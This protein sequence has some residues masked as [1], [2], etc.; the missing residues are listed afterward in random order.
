ML[1]TSDLA[2]QIVD[3]I[4]PI[5]QQN[6]NIMNSQG[7]IIGSGHKH[8]LNTFHKGAEDVIAS[9]QVVEISQDELALYPGALPGLNMPITLNQQVVGVVG[10]SGDP[11]IVRNTAKMVKMVTELILERELLREEFR[12]QSQLQEHF[13][14]LLLSDQAAGNYDKL[15]KTAK[16]LQYQLELARVVLAADV[17]P[18]LE[19]AFHNYGPSDLVS[20]RTKENLLQ[21]ISDSPSITAQDLVVFLENKLVILKHFPAGTTE[22]IQR[23]WAAD[24]HHLLYIASS[25]TPLQVGL[26]S[27]A[28]AY[29]DLNQSYQEALFSLAC[30]KGSA[31]A[32]IYDFDILT[33]YLIGKIRNTPSCQPLNETKTKLE[34]GFSRKYDMKNTVVCLLN[35]HLNISSTAKA[36][37]VHRN[38]L[39]FRL[40]KLREATGLDPCRYLN[41]AIL[42]KI[43]FDD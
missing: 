35:N 1:L 7:F 30:S 41:H 17:K 20:I 29:T 21:L 16:L 26:G 27:L 39:L 8:R 42:C 40:E 13:A 36:L 3:N 31:I 34:N 32:A 2:Q 24:L 43:I 37:Y 11:Q 25:Q 5:A 23:E 33:A 12:S 9:G 19:Q 18:L 4:M 15:F 38:T 14:A 6:I 22:I 28:Q 10:I